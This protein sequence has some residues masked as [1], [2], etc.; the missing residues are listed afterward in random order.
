[1]EHVLDGEELRAAPFQLSTRVKHPG[2]EIFAP[3][4]V[5]DRSP[6]QVG[7]H[8]ASRNEPC[9]SGRINRL[10]NEVP[11]HNISYDSFRIKYKKGLQR[12]ALQDKRVKKGKLPKVVVETLNKGNPSHIKI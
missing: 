1:M 10:D 11:G 2:V 7:V 12:K 8:P 9:V 6:W 5:P 3:D 4:P